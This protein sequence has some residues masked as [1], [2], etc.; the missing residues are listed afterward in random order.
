MYA[1]LGID[2]LT[3]GSTDEYV[4]TAVRL[5]RD[6]AFHAQ[7]VDSIVARRSA[8]FDDPAPLRAL[9]QLLLERSPAR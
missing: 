2:G 5:L 4:A 3:A 8:L 6:P 9:N 7:A 1:L